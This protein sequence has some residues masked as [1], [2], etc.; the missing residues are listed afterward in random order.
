MGG[1][2]EV[3]FIVAHGIP[4][5]RKDLRNMFSFNR[6]AAVLLAASL[7]VPVAP[8][9]ARTKKGDKFLAQGRSQEAKRDWDS[10]LESYENAL[11]EDP[12][13]IGYQMASQKAHFQ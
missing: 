12:A 10:A 1:D 11:A 9:E 5:S 4:A 13:D 8:L 7:L 2:R 3:A 6:L